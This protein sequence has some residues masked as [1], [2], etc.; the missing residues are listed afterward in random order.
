M[1]VGTDLFA[2]ARVLMAAL[3]RPPRR[4]AAVLRDGVERRLHPRRHRRARAAVVAAGPV[5]EV[6]FVCL[7]NICR[8]PY[9]EQRLR[10]AL[11]EAGLGDR[12]RVRSTGFFPPGRSAPDSAVA[13]A[14]ERGVDLSVHRS[15]VISNPVLREADLVLVMTSRQLR[16]LRWNYGRP[17]TLHLGDLEAPPVPRRD[18]PDPYGKPEEAFREVYS[19]IDRASRLLAAVLAEGNPAVDPATE[20]ST[21]GEGASDRGRD[22]APDPDPS[23]VPGDATARIDDAQD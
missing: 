22:G 9:A 3:S 16:D 17:D 15:E 18:L 5:G 2:R 21:R 8:S 7:G 1:T 23:E 10:R 20:G 13:V 12:V 4:L 14:R 19:R 6:L 11:E